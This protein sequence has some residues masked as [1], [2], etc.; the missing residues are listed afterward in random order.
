MTHIRT[1]WAVP[2]L[3]YHYVAIKKQTEDKV[4]NTAKI[5]NRH[6]QVPHLTQ[7]TTWESDINHKQEPRGQPFTSRWPQG[8]IEQTGKHGTHKT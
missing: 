8:S 2:Y 7:D 6:N 4:R 3:L 5:R 1:T